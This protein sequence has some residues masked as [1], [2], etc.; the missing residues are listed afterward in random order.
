MA[1]MNFPERETPKV[2]V[3]RPVPPVIKPNV[4]PDILVKAPPAAPPVKT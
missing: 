4:T 3:V 2:D 1:K